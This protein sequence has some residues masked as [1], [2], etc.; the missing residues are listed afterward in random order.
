M[1]KYS[2]ILKGYWLDIGSIP[3][4]SK[5]VYYTV[6]RIGRHSFYGEPASPLTSVSS[7][8]ASR[9]RQRLRTLV[10]HSVIVTSGLQIVPFTTSL[11]VG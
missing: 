2:P 6:Y 8:D 1:S 7:F 9:L 5:G 3:S 10:A 4:G 11:N